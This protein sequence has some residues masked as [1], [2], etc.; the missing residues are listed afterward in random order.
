[1]KLDSLTVEGTGAVIDLNGH[2]LKVPANALTVNGEVIA[3]GTY[4][5]ETLPT[6]F[7]NGTVEVLSPGLVLVFR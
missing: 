5:G 6:G 1:M 3:K 7:T 4:T 2:T